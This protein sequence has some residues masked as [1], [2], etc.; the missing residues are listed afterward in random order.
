MINLYPGPSKLNP[1]VINSLSSLT[2]VVTMNHRSDSFM[3]L[4]RL[5]KSKLFSKFQIPLDYE[6]CF[7][8]S[9]TECWQILSQ[10]YS[11]LPF[12]HVS[13]GSFGDKWSYVSSTINSE[14]TLS[15]FGI[16]HLP[17]VKTNKK[18][19]ICLTH[20]ETSNGTYLP[21]NHLSF[22][23]RKNEGSLI[24]IDATSSF[25][26]IHLNF[27]DADIV[28]A[29]V[30]KCLGLPA[31]MGL[32]ILSPN[33]IKEAKKDSNAL[34]Y[35]SINNIVNNA[36][37]NQT[38][39]TP[40]ILGVFLLN[41]LLDVIGDSVNT[42]TILRERLYKIQNYYKPN[43]ICDEQEI[44]SPTVMA[45]K[46]EQPSNVINQCMEN[47]IIIGKGYGKWNTSSYRIANFPAHTFDELDKAFRT[48]NR[49]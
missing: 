41:S 9:A 28:F 24:A 7:V 11:K 16:N 17:I 45:I 20:C 32:L 37:K 46:S 12:L 43:F 30:Q 35:N 2:D 26:G 27:N 13:N 22:I 40:N 3:S 19:L 8:S 5:V 18:S 38:T 25:G 48:I 29:S 44:I 49:V 6:L 39:H 42:E 21:S 34:R 4:Y 15:S 47:G 1:S 33:A 14:V 36:N 31:G 23:R 10:S